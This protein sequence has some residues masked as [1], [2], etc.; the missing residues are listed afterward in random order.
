MQTCVEF[1]RNWGTYFTILFLLQQQLLALKFRKNHV[2]R[3]IIRHHIKAPSCLLFNRLNVWFPCLQHAI[4]T[5][6][7]SSHSSAR[8]FDSIYN[9][10][11][12]QMKI[13][14]VLH[15]KLGINIIIN[16]NWFSLLGQVPR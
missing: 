9:K 6:R 3:V 13:F 4:S 1:Y 5:Q 15:I 14:T 12:S 16:I 7:G 2:H 11:I 10:V 8:S